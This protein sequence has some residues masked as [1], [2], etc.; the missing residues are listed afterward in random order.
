MKRS[1]KCLNNLHD[2]HAYFNN[3]HIFNK[4]TGSESRNL[5]E[6]RGDHWLLQQRITI[7][8]PEIS[9]QKWL[10][11]SWDTCSQKLSKE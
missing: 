9:E 2:A 3:S 10:I 5:P 6:K 8:P 11:A 1:P 4:L 7:G